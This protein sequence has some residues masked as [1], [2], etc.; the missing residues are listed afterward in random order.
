MKLNKI[1]QKM[2]N[3]PFLTTFTQLLPTYANSPTH[4]FCLLIKSVT[5]WFT[6]RKQ[7]TLFDWITNYARW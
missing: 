3:L 5:N 1:Q 6:L 4:D 7:D 2:E